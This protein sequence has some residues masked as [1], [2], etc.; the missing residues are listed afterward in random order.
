[1]NAGFGCLPPISER[2]SSLGGQAH[3]SYPTEEWN[4]RG[5]ERHPARSLP[6]LTPRGD[7]LGIRSFRSAHS[8]RCRVRRGVG[9]LAGQRPQCRGDLNPDWSSLFS[10]DSG[11]D[12]FCS[13]RLLGMRPSH[14]S[15]GGLCSRSLVSSLWWSLLSGL[16]VATTFILWGGFVTASASHDYCSVSSACC[17]HK[18][19]DH[20]VPRGC[21]II[22]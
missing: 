3:S 14:S 12:R 21:A 16:K 5:S 18:E 20:L 15:L 13:E 6:K 4:S 1:M 17:T 2:S 11:L 7:D 22:V 8:I 9:H 10:S 19:D